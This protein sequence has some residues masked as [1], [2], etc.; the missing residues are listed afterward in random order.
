MLP[1]AVPKCRELGVNPTDRRNHCHTTVIVVL[2]SLLTTSLSGS[3]SAL[4]LEAFVLL[5]ASTFAARDP[6]FG[7]EG[8]VPLSAA[9]NY[10]IS[11]LNLV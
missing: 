9:Y 1:N 2:T 4:E 6:A 5:D 11:P 8:F 3:V 10:K 7:F